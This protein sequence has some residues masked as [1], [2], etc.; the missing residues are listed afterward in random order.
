MKS[1]LTATLIALCGHL[2]FAGVIGTNVPASPLTAAR[3]ATLPA[4]QQP[5]WK[6]YLE[7][8]ARQLRADQMALQVEMAVRGLSNSIVA[9]ASRSTRSI[10]ADRSADWFAGAEARRITDII[11]SFQTPA[12]GW[13]KNMDFSNHVR[14]SGESF[15]PD[16][17]SRFVGT[18]DYELLGEQ[19]W[20]YVGTIDNGATTTQLRFLAKVITAGKPTATYEH[21]FERGVEYLLAAQNP[22]GGWPQVWPLQ[23]GYHD[24][25]TYNDG[26]MLNVLRL[27]QDVAAGG[28]EFSF[29]SHALRKRAAAS[30]TNGMQCILATQVIENGQRAVWCQQHD[31]LTLL[32]TSARNYEMPSLC[33]GESAGILGFLMEL[34]KPDSNV[35]AAVRGAVAWFERTQIRDAAFRKVANEGRM[36][37]PAPGSGPLWARY[38][39]VGTDKP[40]F[41]DR[42][43]SI[44]DV[45]DDISRERRDGYAWFTDNPKD[46]LKRFQKWNAAK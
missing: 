10:P 12:G 11:V 45:V 9:P 32:P 30:V 29:T 26:A 2:A 41:G 38:Y 6:D 39:E 25:I 18:N 19:R 4:A 46:V 28:K 5:A 43:K 7:R 1:I 20:S 22:N 21:A 13:G 37:V 15:A 40:I 31:A 8:S 24:G 36:L 44:H 27:L 42:D 23:G 17:S 3:I 33:S 14:E 34:P 35:V 16:N